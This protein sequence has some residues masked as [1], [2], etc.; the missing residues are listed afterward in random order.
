[1]DAITDNDFHPP[2]RSDYARVEKRIRGHSR[3][4]SKPLHPESVLF[5]KDVA[6]YQKAYAKAYDGNYPTGGAAYGGLADSETRFLSGLPK[7]LP[8][9]LRMS[10]H[11]N[12]LDDKLHGYTRL[13]V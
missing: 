3:T 8:P 7:K 1:M 6:T 5:P 10:P 12:D 4:L 9:P 13:H 2:R 11:R